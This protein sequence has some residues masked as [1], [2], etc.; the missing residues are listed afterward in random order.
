[1]P[2]STFV[3]TNSAVGLILGSAAVVVAVIFVAA[4][5]VVVVVAVVVAVWWS[6]G[7][8]WPCFGATGGGLA[9]TL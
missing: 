9:C 8:Y 5:V 1:V 6:F 2:K 3:R 4:V 7:W